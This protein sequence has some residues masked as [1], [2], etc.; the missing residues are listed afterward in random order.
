[1]A[2]SMN[3][4]AATHRG[5]VHVVRTGAA[6]P[7]LLAVACSATGS[8]DRARGGGGNGANTSGGGVSVG[9]GGGL[10]FG[11]GN[12]GSG[13][14]S[15]GAK[16]T[17]SGTVYDPAGKTP[18]YN[19]VVY[20][21]IGEPPAIH[22]GPSC[23]KCSGL[24]ARASAVA[25][26]DSAGHF[27]LEGVPPG[28]DVP[29]V[30][31]VGKWRRQVT[32]PEVK[33]CQDN[34]LT[35]PELTRLP[36]NQSEGHLP[37][38]AVTT[39]H[40]DALECLLRKIGIDDAE[41]TTETGNGRVHLFVGCLSKG[42][43]T[44]P[45]HYGANKLLDGTEFPKAT[46]LYGDATR[47]AKYDMIVLSCE[48]HSCADER[49]SA[50]FQN[51]KDYGDKGGRLF[52]DHMHFYWLN[53]SD[54]AWEQAADIAGVGDDLPDPQVVDVDSSFPKGEALA[55]WLVNVKASSTRG[56]LEI[57]AGQFS[58]RAA[59]PPMSQRWIYLDKHPTAG[60]PAVQYMTINTPIAGEEVE[61]EN[62]CGRIV[63]TDLHVSAGAGTD[64]SDQDT[65]FPN[66]C[67]TPTLSAQEKALE[68][69][70]F[71]LSSC[72]QKETEP[73]QPPTVVR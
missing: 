28:K 63:Y 68:F 53:H 40:S 69:M 71:D 59:K 15:N 42:S 66:G 64:S 14:C 12:N 45:A 43:D 23:D 21:P 50:Y 65:P 39:G 1:M 67:R 57:R 5:F 29:L 46:T 25:L 10:G 61:P 9:N 60:E 7:L 41:F 52:F 58:V 70:L 36:R 31:E 22:E 32:L 24:M 55:D 48:G 3:I 6:L 16:T 34:A 4:F 73:P 17:L 54:N 56:K 47:L 20:V 11:G 33:S 8:A 49:E 38:I 44:N 26:S 30:V 2:R 13:D 62:Q 18:L 51:L 72:V 37:R 35:D 19:A 27:T